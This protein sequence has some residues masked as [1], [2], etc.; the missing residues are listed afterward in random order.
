MDASGVKKTKGVLGSYEK[1][2]KGKLLEKLDENIQELNKLKQTIRKLE[3]D[4]KHMQV[5]IETLSN[6]EKKTI[7]TKSADWRDNSDS[8]VL[9]NANNR[10]YRQY[11]L[12]LDRVKVFYMEQHEKQ[13]VAFNI[14]ARINFKTKVRDRMSIWD[15]LIKL[16]ELLDESDPDTE[17]S[18]IDHAI[19]TAE[20]IRR[21]NKPRWFQ[22][23]GLIH[24]LGKL[25]YFFDSE[26]Q[27][28]VVGDTFPVGCKF[29]KR[30]I[31]NEYFKNNIDSKN[32]LYSTK[33]G[34][35]KPHCG[36]SNVMLSWGH[37]EYMYHLAK[38]YSTLPMEGLSMIRYH[39]FYPWH[40]EGAYKYLMNEQD[41]EMLEYVRA[42]NPYDLYSKNDIRYNID[43]LK[44]YYIDL[45]NEF[46]PKQI[47]DF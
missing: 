38:E 1:L 21:D 23:V 12:A 27:W 47:I 5:T 6:T 16:N 36:L 24:D 31:Y 25:L 2:D 39:S 13:T 46:F 20:A 29:S 30:I 19:Q 17:L 10:Q 42:F 15:A 4:K 11:E 28:D 7:V 22:L 3:E 44:P 8:L 35:Y 40:S 9:K 45:I 32:P 33:Y 34:I 14:Q 41:R 26:G 37:D 18:Q 43:E